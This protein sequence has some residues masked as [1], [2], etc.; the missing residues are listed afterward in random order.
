MA[1]LVQTLGAQSNDVG[2]GISEGLSSGLKAGVQLA[3]AKEQVESAKVKLQ[4]QKSELIAKQAATANSLLTNLA[5]ANPAIAK[6]MLKQV[7]EKLINL[8]ADPDVADYTISDDANRKRQ[9]A[10]SQMAGNKLT[11]NPQSAQEYMQGL[12]DLV[13]YDQAAQ[14]FDAEF[15][16]RQQDKQMSQEASMLNKR[17]AAAQESKAAPVSV[18][19]KARDVSFA[20]EY[21][22]FFDAGGYAGV[23]AN[24]KS[25]DTSLDA[26]KAGKATKAEGFVPDKIGEVF[27]PDTAEIRTNVTS[28]LIQGLKDTFGGQLSD[29]ERRAMVESAYVSAADPKA[30][31]KRIEALKSKILEAA[32]AKEEAAQYFEENGTLAGYKGTKRFSIEGK[33]VDVS[34]EKEAPAKDSASMDIEAKKQKA[35]QAGYSPAEVEAY[36]QKLM[37]ARK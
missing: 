37:N 28:V 15:K 19:E 25:L 2:G 16:R 35:I 31:A 4:E 34:P 17:L 27:F 10:F 8:G 32:K 1:S 6:K 5:R 30:N 12:A 33:T 13:G 36:V 29:G 22:Q 9:I 24:L 23:E 26:L 11:Q 14:M 18:G 20:K 21:S 7:R 3:T